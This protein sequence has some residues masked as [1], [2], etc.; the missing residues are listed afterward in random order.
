MAG[1]LEI[2]LVA[3]YSGLPLAAIGAE[4]IQTLP[5]SVQHLPVM[6]LAEQINSALGSTHVLLSAEPGAG[7]STGLPLALMGNR[8]LA[9]KILLLEPRRL[10][11]RL[12]AE[13]LAAH[14]GEPVGQQ[15]GLRMRGE[16]RVSAN[17]R[18]EVLTEGVLTRLL[19]QDPTLS[20]VSLVVFDEFHERSL[21]AD[22]GL[23]M[24]IEVSRALREDLRFLLMSAT[25]PTEQIQASLAQVVHVHCAVRQHPV[26]IVWLGE[27]A[28]PLPQRIMAA[29]LRA[30]SDT[31]GDILVFL[32]GVAEIN[33]TARALQERIPT[34][35]ALHRLHAGSALSEQQRST[36][37][38][39]DGARRRIILATSIA[40]TSITIAGVQ[41]VV[42]SGLERRSRPD[43]STGAQRLET[44]EASQASAT[45]RAGRAGRT[46]AGTCYRLWS[47]SAHARRTVSWQPEILRADLSPLLLE[48]GVW[49]AGEAQ[50][51]PWLL[52]PPDAQLARARQ[53]LNTLGLMVDGKLTPA[54]K[55][56]C[57][58]PV[59]PR[60]AA[61]LLWAQ[62]RGVTELACRLAALLED[63][64]RS[65]SAVD[66]HTETMAPLSSSQQR[67]AK[68]LH[69]SLN[70]G[71]S[72]PE[73]RSPSASVLLAQ[74][75]PDWIA[76]R[77]A[78]DEC[79]FHLA[80]GGGAVMDETSTMA[81]CQWI[82]VAQMGGTG[83]QPRIFRAMA[84]DLDELRYFSPERFR[85]ADFLGWDTREQKV[86]AEHRLM[87]GCLMIESRPMQAIS[88][89]DKALALLNG[90]E[91][92]G[93]AVLPWTEECRQWQARVMRM[94]KLDAQNKESLW[95]DV[96]DAVLVDQMARWLLPWLQGMT[97]LK[98]LQRLDLLK[99]LSAM[100]DYQQQQRLDQWLPRRYVV[101]SGSSIALNYLHPGN[102]VLSV[103]LQEML[104]CADNPTIAQGRIALK[105]ELLSPARRP[106]QV[107]EDLANFWHNSYPAVKKDMAG[108][109]PKHVW[110]E[111]PL[112]A[113]ATAHAKR[114]K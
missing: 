16:T 9:G 79:R 58:L 32:P 104:G 113:Q 76:R 39:A 44:R 8:A 20:G 2:L 91:Q 42:D 46:A 26:E 3:V 62:D 63:S 85:N 28:E 41:A 21:H 51:L 12:V 70:T 83:K 47:E 86:V 11:A 73:E 114:K 69:K 52:A 102:P 74:A 5:A 61:M 82:V 97:T 67:L 64:N 57:Q 106:V 72:Q 48:L 81:H 34:S 15:I 13:R 84:L 40:E 54:G 29:V 37:A 77:R 93:L 31:D 68:Q 50:D 87:L 75:C 33:R 38:S 107:T 89:G 56:A 108:R 80:C 65:A 24:C 88:D 111:E 100:L 4:H 94:H 53:L 1:Q 25:L 98:S 23:A 19:Q 49:G 109:Y 22:L 17:T 92:L 45:Q 59:H 103:R 30:L 96:T 95:P 105:V 66:L 90:I 60:Q 101:P 27:S 99:V 10:A 71:C 36:A 78:G 110:P 112:K 14:L 55:L 7:K 35:V 43:P 18:L 6:A